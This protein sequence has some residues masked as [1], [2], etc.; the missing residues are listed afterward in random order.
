MTTITNPS[1]LLAN[2]NGTLT[3]IDDD[4]IFPSQ[5]TS[6]ILNNTSSQPISNSTMYGTDIINTFG[7]NVVDS[8]YS[9]GTQGYATDN[10]G[11]IYYTQFIYNSGSDGSNISL[12]KYNTS[13]MDKYVKRV[14]TNK[15]DPPPIP[16]QKNINLKDPELKI[17]ALE[18]ILTFSIH[19]F[20]ITQSTII[21]NNNIKNFI[22]KK[23]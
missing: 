5:N 20:S 19:F 9:S 16:K 23:N 10:I 18:S 7:P 1:P 6:Y 22:I 12:V 11:N 4:L 2:T 15:I 13:T 14:I 3:Y 8:E 17:K 21:Y